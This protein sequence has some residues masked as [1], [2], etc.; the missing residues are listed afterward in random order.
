[1]KSSRSCTQQS[2]GESQKREGGR[3][4]PG[5]GQR[6]QGKGVCGRGIAAPI[7]PPHTRHPDRAAPFAPTCAWFSPVSMVMTRPVGDIT[8]MV[9]HDATPSVRHMLILRSFTTWVEGR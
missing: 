5:Q 3:G 7:A 4:D 2:G 9:G 8:A 1:M 6:R